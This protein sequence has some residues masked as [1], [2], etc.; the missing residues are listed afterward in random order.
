MVLRR[1][2]PEL[3]R[4]Q[5]IYVCRGH[6]WEEALEAFG[7]Y[8]G[9]GPIWHIDPGYRR[10]DLILT[11]LGTTPR[12]VLCLEVAVSNEPD[13]DNIRVDHGRTVVF[14]N[15]LSLISIERRIGHQ[16]R[17]NDYLTGRRAKKLLKALEDERA[18]GAPWFGATAAH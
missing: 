2:I 7:S 4:G 1:K 18:S 16:L 9:G 15:G 13:D 10:G 12:V 3:P 17:M 14:E 6:D 8:D 5:R 11:I